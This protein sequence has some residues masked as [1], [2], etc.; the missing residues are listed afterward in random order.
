MQEFQDS[1]ATEDG[2]REYM[3]R[4]RWPEGFRCPR[5]GN[6][7]AW[8]MGRMLF[9]CTECDLETS[10]T[11]GTLFQDTRKPLRLWFQAMWHGT[12]QMH[13]VNALGLQG[14]LGLCSHSA[15]RT[16]LRKLRRAMVRLGE[17]RLPG[18]LEVDENFI[19][20]P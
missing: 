10:L 20:S 4:L 1:F 19:G 18:T 2:C 16:W 11:A 9:R 13:G 8:R 15:A 6:S 17:D 14:L 12:N 7:R 3:L 5:C